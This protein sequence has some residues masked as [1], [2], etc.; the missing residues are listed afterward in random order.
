MN[1]NSLSTG[2]RTHFCLPSN[3]YKNAYSSPNLSFNFPLNR[4]NSIRN[5]SNQAA[6]GG[7]STHLSFNFPPNQLN[8][9]GNIP[10]KPP[11]A[12]ITGGLYT[13][14]PEET[15]YDLLGIPQTGTLSEIKRAY[16]YMALKCHPDVSPPDQVHENTARFIRVQEAY[17][18]LSDPQS[19]AV[20]D[21]NLA[22]GLH[23]AFSGNK[24]SGFGARPGEVVRWKQ[25]WEVQVEELRRWS[26]VEMGQGGRMSWASRIRKQRAGS[27]LDQ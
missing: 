19:R 2:F 7:F 22:K 26:T 25:S 13:Q 21:C 9:I 6:T 5:V 14:S 4:L 1:S 27:D 10:N 12:A 17:E 23:L 3:S 24:G 15:L 18:T 11:N 16:K 8:S 20:Y